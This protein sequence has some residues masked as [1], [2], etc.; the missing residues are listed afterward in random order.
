MSGYGSGL[1]LNSGNRLCLV[2]GVGCVWLWEWA[3][4]NS[5]NWLCL[6]MGIGCVWLQEWA[7]CGYGSGLDSTTTE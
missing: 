2:M 1:C 3:V 4:S 5:W 6:V 7:V